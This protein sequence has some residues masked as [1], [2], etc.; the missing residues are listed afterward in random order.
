MHT[1]KSGIRLI[2]RG[3]DAGSSKSA[4]FAIREAFE[5]GILRNASILACTDLLDHT[6]ETLGSLKSLCIGLHATIACEWKNVHWRPILTKEE[7]PNLANSD[8]FFRAYPVEVANAGVPDD[9]ILREI[10]AQLDKLVNLGF[11]VSYLDLH[12]CFDWIGNL[13]FMIDEFCR[14][15]GLI[16]GFYGYKQLPSVPNCENRIEEFLSSINIAEHGTYLLI[17]HP[18]YD[19]DEMSKFVIEGQNNPVGQSRDIERRLFLDPRVI[20]Y[21]RNGIISPIR[22]DELV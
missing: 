9:I 4:N 18:C 11:N 6:Y 22:Y 5:Y 16:N 15:K 17:G 1:Q 3:D 20:E 2:S 14:K 13:R 12:M 21:S 8:G 7:A 19:D 10:S